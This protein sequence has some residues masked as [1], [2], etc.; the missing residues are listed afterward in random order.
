MIMTFCIISKKARFIVYFD[1]KHIVNER[2]DVKVNGLFKF[3]QSFPTKFDDKFP[4]IYSI[5][6]TR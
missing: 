5:I 6:F 2:V 4:G 1:A 3:K